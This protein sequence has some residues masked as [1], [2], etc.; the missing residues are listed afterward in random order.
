M[1]RPIDAADVSHAIAATP[2]PA[3]DAP[4]LVVAEYL[5]RLAALYRRQA[6]Y[7]AQLAYV[8]ATLSARLDDHEEQIGELHGRLEGMEEVTRLVPEILQR[9]GPQT[10]TPAHQATIKHQATRLHELT[11]ASYATIYG[12]RNAAFHVGRYSDIAEARWLEIAD[13]FKARIDAAERRQRH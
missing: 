4:P 6:A 10:L 11:G 2:K 7:E 8:D 1:T 9:L 3:P 13:W 5:E 12:E